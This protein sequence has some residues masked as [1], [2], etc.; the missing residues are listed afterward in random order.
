MMM[1]GLA[2]DKIYVS[3]S[4]NFG[5]KKVDQLHIQVNPSFLDKLRHFGKTIM[6]KLEAAR[7]SHGKDVH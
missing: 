4:R 7:L 3:P 5:S 6:P 1:H 2:N